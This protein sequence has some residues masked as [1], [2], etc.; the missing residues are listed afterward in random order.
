[1]K[2]DPIEFTLKDGRTAVMRSPVENDIQDML[3]YLYRSSGETEFILRYPE[4]CDRY[5]YEDEKRLFESLDVSENQT[6]I[7]VTVDGR[8]AGASTIAWSSYEKIR[9]RAN[10]SIALLKEFWGLGIGTRVFEELIRIAEK[11]VNIT[12]M[13]LDF[14]EGNERAEALYRKMGFQIT[15]YTP[16]AIRL[17]D[18]RV[19]GEY[20]M[21]REIRR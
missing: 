8:I 15:G 10:V 7:I 19:L 4:E 20:K 9:H 18:G 17:R 5:T 6:M 1:M 3:S 14:V 21:V 13:E 11:N 2:V 16:G 12:Q